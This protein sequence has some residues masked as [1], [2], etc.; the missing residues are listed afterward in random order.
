MPRCQFDGRR[1]ELTRNLLTVYSQAINADIT[2]GLTWYPSAVSGVHAWA[3]VFALPPA[4]VACV[5]AAIS[6]QCNWADNLR[7]ALALL[8]G[9]L[10][11]NGGGALMTNIGKAERVLTD[12]AT[13]LA[14]YFKS[15]PKVTSFARN[16][17]G[18]GTAVTVDTHAAQ[19]ALG[20]VRSTVSLKQ[21]PYDIFADCYR[22]AALQTNLRP[23]D[24]QAIVWHIWKRQYPRTRKIGM[25]R[26]WDAIGE[27]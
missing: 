7:I 1:A 11:G 16:L 27:F 9:R 4:T 14:P 3:S 17:Q 21:T 10:V 6:P 20:D 26:Q 18:I 12:R 23:C 15:G 5:I 22:D 25:R 8:Q 24:F 2:A 19:A 13:D